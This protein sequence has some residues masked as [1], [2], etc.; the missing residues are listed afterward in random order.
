MF[1]VAYGGVGGR[2]PRYG[3]RGGRTERGSASCQN[4]GSLRVD[5]RVAELVLEAIGPAAIEAALQATQCALNEDQE[6]RR[7]LEMALEKARYEAKRAQ[8]QFDAVDPENRLVAAELELRWNQALARVAEIETRIAAQ[9]EQSPSLSA[10]QKGRLRELGNDVSV[11]W[12]HPA[13]PIELKKRIVRTVIEEIVV[14][15]ADQPRQHVLQIHWKGG[16]HTELRL[17]RNGTG[18]TRRVTDEKAI[19]LIAELSKICDDATI[20]QVLNRLGYRTGTGSTWRVHHVQSMRHWR[21]L[22]NHG[23]SGE[24]ISLEETAR[25]LH[26]SNTVIKRLIG[27]NILPAQQVVRY[28][29]WI[30][31][32][33]SLELPAVRNYVDV[34]H[35]GRKH[36]RTRPEQPELPMNMGVL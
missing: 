5:R 6:K 26:V 13:A 27:E 17:T 21:G 36:P 8:R 11:A 3:C 9:R 34:V 12:H 24:W 15:S 31:E 25:E 35:Q 1:F 32:R 7:A 14:N 33:G 22:P 10:E 18:Q 2:V 30:I 29:P 20:A 4:L 28:A 19:E 23:R 16:V